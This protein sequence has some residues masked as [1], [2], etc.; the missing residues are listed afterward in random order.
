MNWQMNDGEF[1][2]WLHGELIGKNTFK[3]YSDAMSRLRSIVN[4]LE[5][6]EYE[7]FIAEEYAND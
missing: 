5:S 6:E 4:T 3:Y 7:Q 2:K 1:L